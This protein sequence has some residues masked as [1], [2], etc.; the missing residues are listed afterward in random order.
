MTD[1]LRTIGVA[2][3]FLAGALGI[4][5]LSAATVLG[6][7]AEDVPSL[8]LVLLAAGAGARRG[9]RDHGGPHRGG[10]SAR[11]HSDGYPRRT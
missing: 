8:A 6:V 11:R 9:D 1:P 7:P 4:T 10:R 5:L 2:L 3:L